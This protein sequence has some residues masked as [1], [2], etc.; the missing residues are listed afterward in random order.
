MHLFPILSPIF[1]LL[2]AGILPVPIGA[3]GGGGIFA[4]CKKRDVNRN[5]PMPK[6]KAFDTPATTPSPP[7]D[8]TST[9]RKTQAMS[10]KFGNLFKIC[11]TSDVDR[12]HPMPKATAHTDHSSTDPSPGLTRSKSTAVH[13]NRTPKRATNLHRNK[14]HRNR[15]SSSSVVQNNSYKEIRFLH[16]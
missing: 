16:L 13:R 8:R 6:V 10:D 14:S 4:I 15:N 1:S 7:T 2:F 5:N 12:N 9:D 11:N 3:A